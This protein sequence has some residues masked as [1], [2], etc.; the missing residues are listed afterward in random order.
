[1]RKWL[2][3]CALAAVLILIVL[4]VVVNQLPPPGISMG[5]PLPPGKVQPQ[6]AIGFDTAALLAP[7]GSLW[8]WGGTDYRLASSSPKAPTRTARAAYN[9]FA[10]KQGRKPTP[11]KPKA[12]LRSALQDASRSRE[13]SA[14]PRGLGARARQ[15]RFDTRTSIIKTGANPLVLLPLPNPLPAGAGRGDAKAR[16]AQNRGKRCD[17][18]A[19]QN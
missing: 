10:S 3:R 16:P 13:P 11:T 9:S 4:L 14:T 12:E 2:T 15:R 19:K 5:T 7:D 18:P 17:L 6:L 8:L 1:M